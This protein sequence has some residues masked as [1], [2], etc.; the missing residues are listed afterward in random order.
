[1]REYVWSSEDGVSTQTHDDSDYNV[2][3][4]CVTVNGKDWGLVATTDAWAQADNGTLN[5]EGEARA[6]SYSDC[7]YNYGQSV[8]EISITTTLGGTYKDYVTHISADYG[9]DVS[10]ADAEATLDGSRTNE[11]S[12]SIY[13][14][15]G[16]VVMEAK[17]CWYDAYQD[18]I[19]T[20]V[21]DN[22]QHN[23]GNYVK[24]DVGHCW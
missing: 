19:M 23:L 4:Q 24:H 5:F 9:Y 16:A 21:I 13:H 1:M 11:Y 15:E 12:Y 6:N 18:D 3:S 7:T 10:Y 17:S 8:D 14:Y 22:E 2:S 20:F